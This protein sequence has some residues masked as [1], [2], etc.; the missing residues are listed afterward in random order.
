MR[1]HPR[2]KRHFALV[3][4]DP[5]VVEIRNGTWNVVSYTLTDEKRTGK[6]FALLDGLDGTIS[7]ADLALR[8]EVSRS[9]VESLIDHLVQLGVIEF[10]P[11]TSFDYYLDQFASPLAFQGHPVQAAREIALVGDEALC[12]EIRDLITETMSDARLVERSR[13]APLEALLAQTDYSWLFDGLETERRMASIADLA[14]TFVIVAD[15]AVH[16]VRLQVMNRV[17]LH[18][19]LPWMQ[20]AIDGPQLLIGPI[21]DPPHTACFEC[22]ET[23]MLMN[24]REAAPYVAYKRLL[25]RGAVRPGGQAMERVLGTMV[26]AHAALEALNFLL[27]GT[28]F[29]RGKVLGIYLPTME[30]SFNEVLQVPG[31]AGCAPVPESSEEELHFD[32]RSLLLAPP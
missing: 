31:C 15:R 4:H 14:G 6:L 27:T 10:G 20:A 26:A 29:T 30:V 18:H 1:S 25:A 11:G 24:A 19:R 12:G 21:V 23:R 5:D 32:M 28:S 8:Q 16:P 13:L 2:L 22:F 7:A 17:A 3:A 9:D